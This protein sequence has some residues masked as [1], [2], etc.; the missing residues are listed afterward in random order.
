MMEKQVRLEEQITK[1]TSSKEGRCG[2]VF[3]M[4]EVVNGPKKKAQE[5]QAIKHPESG[6]LIVSS[7]EIKKTTLEY[8][9][10]VL[11]ENKPAEDVKEVR[12]RQ[13]ELFKEIV[14][15]TDGKFEISRELFEQCVARFEYKKNKL[16]NFLVKA[17]DEFKEAIF[18]LCKR[19]LEDEEIPE[20]FYLTQLLQLYK[21]KGSAQGLKN[22]RFLH[23]KEW[24]PRLCEAMVV[25]G[26]LS[27]KNSTKFQ[28][29]GQ[30]GMRT[31]FHLFAVKSVIGMRERERRGGFL[32]VADIQKYFDKESLQMGCLSLLQGGADRR[33]VRLWYKLNSRCT[34]TAMTGAGPT[35]RGEA[36]PTLG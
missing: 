25:E 14:E 28:I 11:K 34:I 29:G 23:L 7:K 13:E 36:G 15:G 19:I 20:R 22:S 2:K 8:C 26:G 33:A 4:R 35:E 32:T 30:P 16:Y 24:L 10:G 9:L 27:L 31:Q 21:G 12:K 18:C 1:V 6:E 5:A 17:G 3:K